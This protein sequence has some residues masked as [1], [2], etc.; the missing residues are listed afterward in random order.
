MNAQYIQRRVTSKIAK[1]VVIGFVVS[2][3]IGYILWRSFD[4]AR[5]PEIHIKSPEQG[6]IVSA[7]TTEISGLIERAVNLY[8]NGKAT[9]IDE[10]GNFSETLIVFRGDNIITLEA[11]DQFERSIK[12]ELRI[13][14]Q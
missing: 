8:I 2:F 11:R 4:F 3:I 10:K 1:I 5:G 9:T 13:F 7:S 14:G 6:F 12:K